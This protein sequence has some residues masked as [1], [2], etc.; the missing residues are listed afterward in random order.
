M[1]PIP[2]DA[3]PSEKRVSPPAAS[4]N[5]FSP[6]ERWFVRGLIALAVT[7]IAA[8]LWQTIGRDAVL[9]A[10]RLPVFRRVVSLPNSNIEVATNREES[11][12]TSPHSPAMQPA[13]SGLTGL[14]STSRSFD[15]RVAL[16]TVVR[17]AANAVAVGDEAKPPADQPL[18]AKDAAP[19]DNPVPRDKPA[20]SDKP[21][22]VD[23]VSVDLL[24]A[25]AQLVSLGWQ[26]FAYPATWS[27]SETSKPRMLYNSHRSSLLNA[28]AR[29]KPSALSLTQL[30]KD[31]TAA[32]E[33]F[34]DDPRLEYGFGLALWHHGERSEALEVFQTAARLEGTP[35]LPAALAVGWG[36]LLN[37]EE[38]R[39]LDQ[40]SH[41]AK[42][43]GSSSDTASNEDSPLAPALRGEGPG[44]RGSSLGT[45]PAYPTEPQREYAALCL[46]RA[47]GFL[48]GP[49][50]TSELGEA[51]DLTARNVRDHLP[52][53]LLSEFE[54]GFAQVGQRQ[55]DLLQFASLPENALA[56]EHRQQSDELQS[57][58]DTVREE[59]QQARD[60]LARDHLSYLTTV[61]KYVTDTL[62]ARAESSKL[63]PLA[64]KLKASIM[65]LYQPQPHVVVRSPSG[66][67]VPVSSST[68]TSTRSRT[69]RT[70]SLGSSSSSSR[71]SSRNGQ[72]SRGNTNGRPQIFLMPE[73][74][75][76]RAARVAKLEKARTEL[77]RIQTELATLR[78][79]H[80]TLL[81]Q[82]HQA[83]AD[84]KAETKEQQQAQA[85]R[86][87]EQRD[88][89]RK[90]KELNTA[91][92][93]MQSLH[94]SLDTVA[95]Y[96][97]WTTPVEG[98]ALR[99]ALTKKPDPATNASAQK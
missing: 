41:V 33:Q 49:G 46:G 97:P 70:T 82:K 11:R 61:T 81:D 80:K 79:R 5:E 55:S 31:Y 19:S 29:P 71:N 64:Q 83:E 86:R 35:F 50:R 15:E 84:Q 53:S 87:R 8:G 56:T 54:L 94:N 63:N 16:N 95:A 1:N 85:D 58:I 66:E 57:R 59:M 60:E 52:A 98:E 2:R 75:E 13:S 89:E 90:L 88:L 96:V 27:A 25:A 6:R 69:S 67:L 32:R 7:I 22:T 34:H 26:D 77:K 99:Q 21:G 73:T 78:E 42:L 28:I 92:R 76:E 93:Q 17:S 10:R 72:N 40:L 48:T 14:P 45:K 39:G 4:L 23:A 30:R 74:T 51:A 24:Q 18:V 38:R 9:A 36:R 91:L 12:T 20:M 62:K 68:S 65:Q 47:F 37:G 3:S 44:V 43:I